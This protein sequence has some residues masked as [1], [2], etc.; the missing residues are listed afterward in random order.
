MLNWQRTAGAG[1]AAA[2][3]AAGAAVAAAA[4]SAAIPAVVPGAAAAVEAGTCMP[5]VEAAAAPENVRVR[6]YGRSFDNRD[7]TMVFS[8]LS[9]LHNQEK[10]KLSAEIIQKK[11]V[12]EYCTYQ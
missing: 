7:C 1:A 2:A 10:F 8:F 6:D 11:N 5:V 9:S 4:A 3:A 12:I